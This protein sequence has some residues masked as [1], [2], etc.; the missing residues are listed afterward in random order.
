[1]LVLRNFKQLAIAK[2]SIRDVCSTEDIQWWYWGVRDDIGT[3][4]NFSIRA[5][6]ESGR[7]GVTLAR[8]FCT[9]FT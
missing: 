7:G 8:F 6:P 4:K 9:V 3:K 2:N 1:M 5:L